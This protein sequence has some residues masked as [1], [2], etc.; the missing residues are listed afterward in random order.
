MKN[1]DTNEKLYMI[2]KPFL[3]YFHYI[4]AEMELGKDGLLGQNQAS[5]DTDLAK[6]RA[7]MISS[8]LSDISY[9]KLLNRY[10]IDN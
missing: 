10:V 6:A 3:H 4:V 5:S 1:I 2:S 9:N 8:S 7:K